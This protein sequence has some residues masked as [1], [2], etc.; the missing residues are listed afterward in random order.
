MKAKVKAKSKDNCIVHVYK[1]LE[2]GLWTE[3]GTLNVDTTYREEE[4]EFLNISL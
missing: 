2:T 3:D 1:N 4:L